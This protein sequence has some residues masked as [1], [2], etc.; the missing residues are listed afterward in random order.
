MRELMLV[1][2]PQHSGRRGRNPVYVAPYSY[3][4]PSIHKR[5]HVPGYVKNLPGERNPRGG[6]MARNQLGMQAISR[7]WLQ[8]VDL[9]EAGAALGGLAL[10]TML[11][12]MFVK[13]TAT[14]TG[15]W[16]KIGASALAAIGAGWIFRNVSSTAGKYAVAGGLAGTLQQALSAFGIVQIGSPGMRHIPLRR[17][18]GGVYPETAVSEESR[19]ITNVT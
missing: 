2:N 4:K 6:K 17:G 16:M 8:G 15:K 10:S 19:I 5:V 3:H 7:Q 1:E 9:M 12:G 14:T 11:P 18:L 13:D